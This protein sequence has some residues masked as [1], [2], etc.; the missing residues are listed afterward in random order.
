MAADYTI[1]TAIAIA[2]TPEDV[3]DFVTTPDNWPKF[4]PLTIRVE[5]AIAAPLPLGGQ[6]IEHVWVGAWRTDH[7][8]AIDTTDNK[9]VP[10]MEPATDEGTVDMQM[11]AMTEEAR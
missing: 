8:A 2:R 9:T 11:L 6:C 7:L 3:F 4:W 1:R 10:G 5:G